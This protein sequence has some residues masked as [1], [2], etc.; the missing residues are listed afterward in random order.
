VGTKRA[1]KGAKEIDSIQRNLNLDFNSWKAS[2]EVY[3]I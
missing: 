3:A 2:G 1:W